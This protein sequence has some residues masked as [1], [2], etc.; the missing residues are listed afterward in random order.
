MNLSIPH[1][2]LLL[3][4][5]LF[6]IG[7]AGFLRFRDQPAAIGALCLIFESA[8]IN[9]IGSDVSYHSGT[10]QILTILLII[11]TISNILI[12]ASFDID[13]EPAPTPPKHNSDPS[14][15]MP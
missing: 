1:F 4:G 12:L 6:L 3:S 7:L 11:S 15:L 2:M 5:L 10:G 13:S 9:F 8:A 14:E